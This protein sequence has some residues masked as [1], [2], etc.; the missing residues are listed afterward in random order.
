[1]VAYSHQFPLRPVSRQCWYH[2][3]TA[4]KHPQS[5]QQS[6]GITHNKGHEELEYD[7][8]PRPVYNTYADALWIQGCIAKS[9][10]ITESKK[11]T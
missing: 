7:N 1:M 11:E 10:L 5:S 2:P 6:Y 9:A 8:F 3:T 4:I